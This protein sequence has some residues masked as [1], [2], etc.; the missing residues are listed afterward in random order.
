MYKE[1]VETYT[2]MHARIHTCNIY[3]S[4]LHICVYKK[5]VC[6]LICIS[7]VRIHVFHTSS[8]DM[9]ALSCNGM[10]RHVHCGR[11]WQGVAW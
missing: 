5:S 8:K 1:R 9:N 2:S 6:M 7:D 10:Y 4:T 3:I 11:V